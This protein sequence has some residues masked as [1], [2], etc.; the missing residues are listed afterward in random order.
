MKTLTDVTEKP[1]RAEA[2]WKTKSI[3]QS[4]LLHPPKAPRRMAYGQ[5]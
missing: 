5:F 3:F 2:H 4:R 1:G